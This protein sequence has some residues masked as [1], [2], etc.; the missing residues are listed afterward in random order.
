M[1]GRTRYAFLLIV[2]VVVCFLHSE[3]MCGN[4]RI[5]CKRW[6]C[7]ARLAWSTRRSIRIDERDFNFFDEHL[8]TTIFTSKHI[9]HALTRLE[10]NANW[11]EKKEPSL[12]AL[13][14]H[15]PNLEHLYL[16][17]VILKSY[18]SDKRRNDLI[19]AC[20]VLF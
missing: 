13:A 8:L 4:V 16:R 18:K 9:G 20:C 5:V 15:C 6:R 7:V 17:Q 11:L 14:Q 19:R 3:K 2:V 1:H 12:A 10:L